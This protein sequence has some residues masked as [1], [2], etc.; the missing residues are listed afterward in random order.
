[1]RH[2]LS[3]LVE[4]KPGVLGR[5]VGLVARRG[6]NIDSLSVGPTQD[7]NYSKITAIVDSNKVAFEQISKQLNKLIGVYKITKLPYD[8]AI[9]RELVLFKI[10]APA[11]KRAEIIEI[12]NI[13][14]GKIVDVGTDSVT[15]EA[16]GDESKMQA[17][18]DVLIDYGIIEIAR[19]GKIAMARSNSRS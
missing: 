9:Q 7:E 5:V 4:N 17:M 13:F 1:M 6:F 10:E 12:T 14:R 11:N 19:T 18:E 8:A 15:V 3:V 16:T 2:I